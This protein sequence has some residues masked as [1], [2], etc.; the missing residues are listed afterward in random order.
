MENAERLG[1]VVASKYR[2][3]ILVKLLYGPLTPAQLCEELSLLSEQ[4]SRTLKELLGKRLITCLNPKAKKGRLYT[5][6]LQGKK[7]A[8]KLS[9]EDDGYERKTF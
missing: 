7:I 3:K 5:L 8:L 4:V 6:T 1:F 2:K 9:E